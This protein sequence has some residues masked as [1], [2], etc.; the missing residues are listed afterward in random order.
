MS[1]RSEQRN[2]EARARLAPLAPGERPT[3]LVV[4]AAVATV[5]AVLNVVLTLAADDPD[6]GDLAFTAVQA[7]VLLVVA[8]G[9]WQ[10]RYLAVLAFQALLAFQILNFTVGALL[11][12]RWLV[13]LGFAVAVIALG[14]LF[15]KL[16]P[17]LARLQTP[18][19]KPGR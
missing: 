16:V 9:M 3:V 14:W 1:E 12:N 11:G 6:R 7:V 8:A 10:R 5:L 2:A 19:R 15:W 18:A 13:Q 17:T 4:A